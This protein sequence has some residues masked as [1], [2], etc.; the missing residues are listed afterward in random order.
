VSGKAIFLTIKGAVISNPQQNGHMYLEI[1]ADGSTNWLAMDYVACRNNQAAGTGGGSVQSGGPN[2]AVGR[3]LQAYV[4]AGWW[5]RI[6]TQTITNY[7]AP[8]YVYDNP[9]NYWVIG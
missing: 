6:R 9:G 4:P 3:G 1:S 2:I 8:T 7:S 5:Y